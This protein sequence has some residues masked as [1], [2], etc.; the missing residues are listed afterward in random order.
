MTDIKH[1]SCSGCDNFNYQCACLHEGDEYP[2]W[3]NLSQYLDKHP[4]SQK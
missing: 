4:R 2:C 1:D 3:F